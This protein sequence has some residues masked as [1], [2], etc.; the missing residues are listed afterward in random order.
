MLFGSWESNE[1]C[2]LLW[3]SVVWG[4]GRDPW[5]ALSTATFFFVAVWD[6]AQLGLVPGSSRHTENY[7]RDELRSSRVLVELGMEVLI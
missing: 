1:H 4:H 2:D 5:V 7:D 6:Y 3:N